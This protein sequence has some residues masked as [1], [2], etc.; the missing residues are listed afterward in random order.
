MKE[1]LVRGLWELSVKKIFTSIFFFQEGEKS[2]IVRHS[3]D[4]EIK[5]KLA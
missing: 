2:P 4:K 3:N 5:A 1:A